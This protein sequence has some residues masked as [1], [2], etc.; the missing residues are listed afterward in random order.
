[1]QA[2]LE[3]LIGFFANTLVLR[4]DTGVE[5]LGEYL[6]QVRQVHMDAQE[7]QDLPFEQL[8]EGLNI[9]RDTAHT[10]VFQIMLTTGNNHGGQDNDALTHTIPGVQLRPIESGSATGQV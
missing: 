8:V 7:H 4:V 5:T 3:P 9:P 6:G 10:P 1:M 2:E